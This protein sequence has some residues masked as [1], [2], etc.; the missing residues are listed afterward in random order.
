MPSQASDQTCVSGATPERV[1][2]LR[3]NLARIE[4]RFDADIW[5][6]VDDWALQVRDL[7]LDTKA[8]EAHRQ[9]I[10]ALTQE[11]SERCRG[12]VLLEGVSPPWV[13]EALLT[14]PAPESSPFFQQRIVVLQRDWFELFDGLSLTDLGESLA[15]PRLVWFVGD[16]ASERLLAWFA[17][18]IDDAPPSYVVQNPGL[19]TKTSP[20]AP[21]LFGEIER[22]W[23][24][25][26][27]EL[28]QA[29]DKRA[30]RDMAWWAKRYAGA[31]PE[32]GP[33]RVLVPVSRY[34]T[35]LQHIAN[36]LQ[37]ALHANGMECEI[38]IERDAHTAMSQCAIMRAIASFD[39]D[40]IISINYTRRSLGQHIPA[41][42]PH[43]CWIQDAMEHLLRP[44]AGKAIG[45]HDFVVGMISQE[46]IKHYHYPA[47]RTKWMPMVASR[48]KFNNAQAATSFD[49]EIAWVTHQSE[50][51]DI[52]RDRL[53][54][55]MDA[56]APHL[57]PPLRALL[58]EVQLITRTNTQTHLFRA[59]QGAIDDHFFPNGVPDGA[60]QLRSNLKFSM[61]VPYAERVLRHQ[62]AAWVAEIA[63]RRGWRFKLYGKGWENHTE[64]SDYAA[65]PLEHGDALR[66]VYQ[67]SV[68]QLHASMNQITHQRVSE[69]ILSGGLPLCRALLDSFEQLNL[70][71]AIECDLLP[72]DGSLDDAQ[73]PE[74]LWYLPIEA[75]TAPARYVADL[76]RLGLCD[77][78][79][80]PDNRLYWRTRRVMLAQSRLRERAPR[81]NAEMFATMTDLCF[82]SP[83][84]LESLIERA[85]EDPQW[86]Q[87][88]I[89]QAQQQ[90]PAVMTTEG[91]LDEVFQLIAT[92][93][94]DQSN[95]AS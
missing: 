68:V 22:R 40:L 43:L 65:G 42:I 32:H 66:R 95:A 36:D 91:F 4:D 2:V 12:P 41:D 62:T 8:R 77:P 92:T 59:I 86:R 64:L 16:D 53:L 10:A 76:T 55:E 27:T 79:A 89:E 87:D 17:E 21:A 24:Q 14:T 71:L 58:D 56:A 63:K 70:L 73:L 54:A 52:M 72:A 3:R 57:V 19:R 74:K 49:A 23:T 33:M 18:R 31:F 60:Q 26:E 1:E 80:F 29:L 28:I 13:L 5:A 45:T 51:P 84:V 9:A 15:D 35:Y 20:D 69:C 78:A 75:G 47:A 38:I 37:H 11:L 82:A 34:T 44:D 61:V 90:L 7:E 83:Q 48:H 88:R 67:R 30:A 6:R 85:V 46:H 50:H 25:N 39:P 81:E 93:L 94:H